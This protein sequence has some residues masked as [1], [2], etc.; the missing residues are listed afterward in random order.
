MRHCL[1]RP[2]VAR[3]NAAPPRGVPPLRK[4]QERGGRKAAKKLKSQLEGWFVRHRRG[5]VRVA[6]RSVGCIWIVRRDF[7]TRRLWN[8][9]FGSRGSRI[10]ITGNGA[11][12]QHRFTR[13]ASAAAFLSL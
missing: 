9:L 5:Q 1:G 2:R 13:R 6:A 12:F 11:K 4:R 7:W 3:E 8:R 10:G